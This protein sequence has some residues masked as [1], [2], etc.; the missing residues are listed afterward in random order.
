MKFY[1]CCS[2]GPKGDEGPPGRQG[3]PGMRGNL[4]MKGEQG[5]PGKSN[6]TVIPGDK[7]DKGDRGPPGPPGR[8]GNCRTS[9]FLLML[10]N[11]FLIKKNVR[12]LALSNVLS[13][14]VNVKSLYNRN[15]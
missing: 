8:N 12:L 13:R 5:P 10:R 11:F 2:A 1:I 9:T 7:G 15:S 4:G 3:F 14:H 6:A